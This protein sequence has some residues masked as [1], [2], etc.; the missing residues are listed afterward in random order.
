MPS[1]SR[2]Q[3]LLTGT[4][5]P[6]EQIARIVER[7]PDAIAE[8]VDSIDHRALSEKRPLSLRLVMEMVGDNDSATSRMYSE[9][10]DEQ[11]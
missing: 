6:I 8:F 4:R 7:T 5:L 1:Q 11:V 10:V 3:A 2:I 9:P